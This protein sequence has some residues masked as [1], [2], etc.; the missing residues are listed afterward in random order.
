MVLP[1]K[2]AGALGDGGVELVE[3]VGGADHADAIVGFETVDLI[4]EVGADLVGDEGVEVLEDEESGRHC[5]CPDEDL[6]DALFGAA[7]GAVVEVLDVE[8]GDFAIATLEG[9]DE[10]FDAECFTVAGGAVE[11]D[12]AF[13]RNVEGG[14]HFFRVEEGGDVADDSFFERGG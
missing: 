9:V 4:E 6:A 8:A 3:M 2:A 1:V 12:T 10:G 11:N 13:P 14:V 5:P 7:V